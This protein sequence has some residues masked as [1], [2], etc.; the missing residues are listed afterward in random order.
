M[1]VVLDEGVARDGEEARGGWV[2]PRL[3]AQV[4]PASAPIVGIRLTTKPVNLA[5]V[6]S[7]PNAAR[8]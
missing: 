8:R 3:L 7:A 4:E 2:A 6:R 1:D 5:T